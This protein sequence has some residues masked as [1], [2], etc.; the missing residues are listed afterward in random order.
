PDDAA[1]VDAPAHV[2]A[3]VHAAAPADGT[4]GREAG[5][6]GA[7]LAWLR[8][9]AAERAAAGDPP[10]TVVE[11][12]VGEPGLLGGLRGTV[13]VV[14]C[15]PPYVP[16]ATPVPPEV[17]DHDPAAAVFGG[18]DGLAVIRPVAALAAALLRPGGAVG[19]EHDDT[20]ADAVPALLTADGRFAEIVRHRDLAGRPRF[21]AARRDGRLAPRDALRLP[22]AG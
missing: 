7:A 9:N 16:D 5:R 22:D 18:A 8:R 2:R 13:D 12:D 4:E 3:A 20:H 14:L 1:T 19:I 17:A 21:A 11:G 6:E 15:N 10:V